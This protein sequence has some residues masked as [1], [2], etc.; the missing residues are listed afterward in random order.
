MLDAWGF[1]HKT[2]LTWFKDKMGVGH[3]LRGQTEHCL[4]AVRG[5]PLVELTNQTTAL[6]EKVRAHSQKPEAFYELVERLCPAPRYAGLFSRDSR[7]GWDMHGDEADCS[8]GGIAARTPCNVRR[9]PG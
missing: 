5:H 3:W 4:M 7:P 8:L 1:E 6:F 9:P 2:T